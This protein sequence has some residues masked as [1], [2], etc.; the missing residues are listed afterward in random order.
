LI[1]AHVVYLVST[2][3]EL[4]AL[5]GNPLHFRLMAAELADLHLVHTELGRLCPGSTAPAG[6]RHE[7]SK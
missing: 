3:A 7:R 5:A 1:A 6:W 4:E 2:V